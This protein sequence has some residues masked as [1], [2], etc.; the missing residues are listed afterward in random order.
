MKFLDEACPWGSPVVPG[1]PLPPFESE[2]EHHRYIRM[3]QMHL[4]LLDDG[5]P[6]LSTVALSL[7]LEPARFRQEPSDSSWLT[8][9]ELAVSLT[10][11]FP[12][13][14]TPDLFARTLSQTLQ[15]PPTFGGQSWHWLYDPDFVASPHPSG[16]WNVIRHERGTRDTER[17]TDDR[18]LVVLW[19]FHF[20]A[21]FAFPLAHG[22][23]EADVV[24]LAP[25]SLAVSEADRKDA[26]FPYRE[27][28][29]AERAAAL[30]A[31]QEHKRPS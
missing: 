17:L 28:W 12:A 1:V 3:L 25:A 19:M 9:L 4:A 16:G 11:W 7:A 6:S 2:A 26:A 15:D 31:A 20:R 14:W 23:D 29:R 30:T 22:Y 8:P 24:A 5:P 10:S 27:A 18:D 21:K 13:P